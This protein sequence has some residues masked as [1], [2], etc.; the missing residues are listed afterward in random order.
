LSAYGVGPRQ[1]LTA[2]V[3][4]KLE[5]NNLSKNL[6][7]I[8]DYRQHVRELEQAYIGVEQ[9]NAD[10]RRLVRRKAAIAYESYVHGQCE[11]SSPAK[12]KIEYARTHADTIVYKVIDILLDDYKGAAEIKVAHEIAHLAISLIVFDAVVECEVLERP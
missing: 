2:E 3:I 7:V 6:R 9:Q 1:A 5:Y 12:T 11:E 8:T 4:E 10:A